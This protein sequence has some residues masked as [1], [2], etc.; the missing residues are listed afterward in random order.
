M[1]KFTVLEEDDV[2]VARSL[3]VEMASEGDTREEAIANLQEALA[4][5]YEPTGTGTTHITPADGN[6]F[7]DLGFTPQEAAAL[8][9]KSDR[10][11]AACFALKDHL[12]AELCAWMAETHLSLAEAAQKLG[13][14]TVQIIELYGKDYA[15]FTIESLIN[16]LLKASKHIS[17]IVSKEMPC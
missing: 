9:A 6:I 5:Y 11:I 15:Q 4:L 14:T 8:K 3:D 7:A 12:M 2:F 17:V 13:I 10:I 1:K 16:L